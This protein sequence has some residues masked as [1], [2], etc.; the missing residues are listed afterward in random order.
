MQEVFLKVLLSIASFRGESTLETWIYRIAL[1]EAHDARRWHR[2]H[3]GRE[4]TTGGSR[5]SESCW[6]GTFADGSPSPFEQAALR[7]LQS[8]VVV[9]LARL[10]PPLP[11]GPGPSRNR[12]PAVYQHR[13]HSACPRFD[14][15][16][17]RLPGSPAASDR[18]APIRSASPPQIRNCLTVW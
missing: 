18:T 15:Q 5:D 1:N 12:R 10:D 4:V 8:S 14:R 13:G 9:A 11:P 7:E 6:L 3:C 2:R 17:S 16:T